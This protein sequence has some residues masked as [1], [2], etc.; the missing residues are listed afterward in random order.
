MPESVFITSLGCPKN[1]VDSE[2]MLGVL[3]AA[4]YEITSREKEAWVI[5][6]NTCAFI[7]PAVEESIETILALAENKKRGSLRY[8]VVTGCFPQR[9]GKKLIKLL[10]EV[11]AFIGTDGFQ[12]IGE[13]LRSLKDGLVQ[14]L[15]L[16][17]SSCFIMDEYTPRRRTTPFY[18]AY[19]KIA[20]GCGHHCSFCLIPRLRGKLRS[21]PVDSVFAEASRLAGEGARELILVA[22]DTSA[23]GSDLGDGTGLTNLLKKLLTIPGLDWIRLLYLYPTAIDNELLELM[24]SEPRICPYLD[25]PIQ[26]ISSRV[27]RLMRRPYDQ[28]YIYALIE[29]IRRKLPEAALRTSLIAGFPGETGEEFQKLLRLVKEARFEH[30]GV[31]P[32]AAEDGTVAGRLPGQLPEK[33]KRERQKKILKA[34]QDIS[35]AINRSRVGKI[36]PVLVEGLSD[37]TELLLKGRAVFQAP[38]IDGQV[39][40]ASGQTEIGRIASVRI[41]EAHPYDLVGEVVAT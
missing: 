39:Y 21:R 12:N 8:L 19:L 5:I 36:I 37:E 3:I 18:T 6:I 24:A 31:F 17:R 10:P 32:Y 23:Y 13:V 22:Q 9:Y 2:V 15:S 40:I 20:E 38:D 35:L 28:D 7:Q 29:K 34:Q 1:L 27:L 26:H 11:D 33:V 25:I 4:G 16:P 41:T 14:P 30:V